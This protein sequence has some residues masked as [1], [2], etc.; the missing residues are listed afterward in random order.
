MFTIILLIFF[1]SFSD[2][3]A[4]DID[5]D[6]E[7]KLLNEFEVQVITPDTDSNKINIEDQKI[8]S[9]PSSNV[10]DKSDKLVVEEQ[11]E[12]ESVQD[13]SVPENS[14]QGNVKNNI[15]DSTE[16]NSQLEQT[17]EENLQEIKGNNLTVD[18]SQI[19]ENITPEVKAKVKEEE[20]ID[21]DKN[22]KQ[23][24]VKGID[25]SL[26]E[27]DKEFL[28]II[29]G[30]SLL[31]TKEQLLQLESVLEAVRTGVKIQEKDIVSED[32]KVV[33]TNKEA[34]TKSSISF[35][36][37]SIMYHSKNDWVIWINGNKITQDYNNTD[38]KIVRVRNN[39]I[40]CSWTTGY[41]KFVNSL[42]KF[43]NE[44]LMPKNT[45]VQISD[46][47]ATVEFMLKPNQSFNMSNNIFIN[48][49]K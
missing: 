25:E 28:D 15:T 16:S 35:Y 14:N 42:I 43:N 41:G 40:K 49:G 20:S 10:S 4:E 34:V 37:N 22:D 46:N 17:Q 23:Q 21:D 48:E 9:T 18:E 31:H 36:L 27:I 19:G 8:E 45:S 24:T 5:I 1:S 11:V 29:Q 32:K 26:K 2:S 44:N 7:K 33:V 30:S 47:I 3:F 39:H 13:I 38:L 12:K 6:L